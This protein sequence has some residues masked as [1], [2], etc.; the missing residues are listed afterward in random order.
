MIE[1]N[2]ATNQEN[3][4]RIWNE[5]NEAWEHY[6]AAY[7]AACGP[8]IAAEA[9][10][11]LRHGDVS[12]TP[13]GIRVR[14]RDDLGETRSDSGPNDY[15]PSWVELEPKGAEVRVCTPTCGCNSIE[16][17]KVL[18]SHV[19]A[20]FIYDRWLHDISDVV[21]GHHKFYQEIDFPTESLS[22]SRLPTGQSSMFAARRA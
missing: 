18:C 20:A 5:W 9:L 1:K 15:W 22:G 11:R 6:A 13:K 3:Q 4:L 12:V 17:G 10:D 19:I 2:N 14:M 21:G 16:N 7:A 8:H